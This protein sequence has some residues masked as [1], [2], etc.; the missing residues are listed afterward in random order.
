MSDVKGSGNWG[1]WVL[2]PAPP[3][4]FVIAEDTEYLVDKAQDVSCFVLKTLVPTVILQGI[5]ACHC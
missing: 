3:L 1:L 5:S 2:F 4:I